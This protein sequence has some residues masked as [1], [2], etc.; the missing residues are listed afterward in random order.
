MVRGEVEDKLKRCSKCKELKDIRQFRKHQGFPMGVNSSCSLCDGISN[1]RYYQNNR[2]KC[3]K[4]KHQYHSD[5][6]ENIHKAKRQYYLSNSEHISKKAR[7]YELKHPDKRIEWRRR[8]VNSHS[9]LIKERG[10]R[11][12][13]RIV[14]Q[15]EDSYIKGILFNF[16]GIPREQITDELIEL[17]KFRIKNKR[18]IKKLKGG[19]YVRTSEAN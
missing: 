3:L 2:E 18:E 19:T 8:Y 11:Y 17:E 16:Y 15:L 14:H 5:H 7:E 9:E 10:R 4:K 1:K 13:S 12:I 6:R